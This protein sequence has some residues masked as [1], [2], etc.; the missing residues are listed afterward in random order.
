MVGGLLP[1]VA[2]TVI[3]EVYGTLA[4]LV[5]GMVF[6]V[7]EILW[8]WRTQGRVEALTWGTNALI[9]I[10]GGISLLT[11]DG[12]WFKL[13]PAILEGVFVLFL[14]GSLVLRKPL[15]SA[16][17][18]K[19]RPE[20]VRG[21]PPE[22][23][24]GLRGMTLRLGV[25]FA[26]HCALAIWAALHWSTAAWAALKGVGLTVSLLLYSLAEGAFLRY[27]LLHHRT[28]KRGASLPD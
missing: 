6:G 25:F 3:E 11:S 20:F 26:L 19:Q 23:E 28:G 24:A 2:F 18:R 17:I 21:L 22:M 12:L 5:A 4:G 1:L 7:G 15:L 16:L 10:L 8:E 14:W 13:Q 27:R 9:L